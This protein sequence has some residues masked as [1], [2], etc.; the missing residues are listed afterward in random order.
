MKADHRGRTKIQD[1]SGNGSE[2]YEESSGTDDEDNIDAKF[3]R[4][5]MSVD[6]GLYDDP[7]DT[8]GSV[9]KAN[10]TY[11]SNENLA[12]SDD[13]YDNTTGMD[14][15]GV[16]DNHTAGDMDDDADAGGGYLDVVPSA[17][18]GEDGSDDEE[19]DEDDND[20]NNEDNNGDEDEDE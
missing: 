6:E 9:S 20:D 3:N 14:G 1:G 17:A 15:G 10:P 8:G 5:R 2:D 18:D 13:L 7:Q 11:S 4:L 12:A 16:Y 19:E